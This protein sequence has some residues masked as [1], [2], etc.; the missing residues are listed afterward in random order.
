MN[1]KQTATEGRMNVT[2]KKFSGK[3]VSWVLFPES[4]AVN[5]MTLKVKV[6]SFEENN[7]NAGVF[8]GAFQTSG[9]YLFNSMSIRNQAND[10]AVSPYWV[11]VNSKDTSKD[12]NS[13]NGS[14]KATYTT[15]DTYNVTVEKKDGVYTISWQLGSAAAVSKTFTSSDSYLL[16]QA[17]QFGI[18]ITSADVTISDWIAYDANGN[19]V[20]EQG[21]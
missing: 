10:N 16:N 14:P 19:T 17:A 11:K 7:A 6:N 2:A 21:K 12:G 20:Y 3:G 8:V 1:I 13:G 4:E 5:K 15:G 18:A 9:E